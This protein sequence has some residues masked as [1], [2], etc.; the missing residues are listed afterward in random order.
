MMH[1]R[2]AM[3]LCLSLTALSFSS[4]SHTLEESAAL[5]WLTVPR[6]LSRTSDTQVCPHQ[7]DIHLNLF[8]K[9]IELHLK[10]N[11]YLLTHNYTLKLQKARG[12]REF[13]TTS[14]A[15]CL[16]GG[17]MRG[18]SNSFVVLSTRKG[19]RGLLNTGIEAF[20]IEPAAGRMEDIENMEQDLREDKNKNERNS[21]KEDV[22]IGK[23]KQN[24]FEKPIHHKWSQRW[25]DSEE[26]MKK[27]KEKG[28]I[29]GVQNRFDQGERRINDQPKSKRK[30]KESWNWRNF[31]MHEIRQALDID[32]RHGSCGNQNDSGWA[33]DNAQVWSHRHHRRMKRDEGATNMHV[34]LLLVA[35]AAEFNKQGRNARA[36]ESRLIE[37]AHLVHEFY[38]PLGVVVA[39]VGIEIWTAGDLIRV[40]S[41][42][43][44][45]LTQFL[46]WRQR[47]LAPQRHH[48]SAQLITGVQFAG[49]TVG[50]APLG[51]ICSPDL[52]GGIT[53][54][55]SS[56][57]L[58]TAATLA[59]E[60]GH[61]LGMKHDDNTCRCHSSHCIMAP[62]LSTPF[63]STF[64]QC[65]RK[66]LQMTVTRPTSA[67]L[68]NRPRY[69]FEGA[70]CGNGYLEP[71]EACDCGPPQVCQNP[72][73]FANNC[74]LRPG[75]VCAHG[76]CCKNCQ[77]LP[78][79]TL[80]RPSHDPCDLEEFC[81]GFEP[82]CPTD[83]HR[84]DGAACE[85]MGSCYAG[86]CRSLARQCQELWG[87]GARPSSP[88]CFT[89]VN[90]AGDQYGN[91]GKDDMDQYIKCRTSD[92]LC[93]KVQCSSQAPTPII[94]P[95]AV[96][97]ETDVPDDRGYK[98]KCRG[99]HLYTAADVPD[100][101][102]TQLGSWCA[103]GKACQAGRCQ[104]VVELGFKNCTKK[105]HGHGECNNHGNCHCQ[106]GW[107]P[108]DCS[109]RG[110]GGSIDSGQMP[111]LPS[112]LSTIL[113]LVL[114]LTLG[115]VAALAVLCWWNRH[116]S[117]FQRA[118]VWCS[119]QSISKPGQNEQHGQPN[120]LFGKEKETGTM[121]D[122]FL[123][124]A[125]QT[126]NRPTYPP[127]MPPPPPKANSQPPARPPP[128]MKPLP[129]KP[130]GTSNNQTQ[131]FSN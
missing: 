25:R 2:T 56:V 125:M 51:G 76:G 112:L 74:T 108:P 100:P 86:H 10:K 78:A 65:S 71:E 123:L 83:V 101:G 69:L 1:R 103:P 128:P 41:D 26:K 38:Q 85:P 66:S 116:H 129:K 72:C 35:D 90:A 42:P 57:V 77:L 111:V 105:C 5:P 16:Y 22:H 13:G 95:A 91:C 119:R 117:V 94:S 49:S 40:T 99:V 62:A 30:K 82:I 109:Q 6:L 29:N 4:S 68:A 107:A 46:S 17:H 12:S 53:M 45:T 93:G 106:S 75:A 19:L 23:Q 118:R 115:L 44:M 87:P 31:G 124:R 113:P 79:S 73:C 48:D 39:L 28:R 59:H 104:P 92:A 88:H 34:E 21:Q 11:D 33:W 9:D 37:M 96:S 67:C 36:T 97:I 70:R 58:G 27:G 50:M 60:L 64:S 24:R 84:Q 131:T 127:P 7:V 130:N 55:H 20:F 15:D 114:V 47:E 81:R 61:G 18:M 110:T 54:D 32:F 52:S 8:G 126:R 63:P 102:L 3:S 120:L 121:P 122:S 80:C 98:E 89:K 14:G 43:Q